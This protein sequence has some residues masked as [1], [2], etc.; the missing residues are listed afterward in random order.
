MKKYVSLLLAV[1]LML[2]VLVAIPAASASPDTTQ[3]EAPILLEQVASGKLPPLEER[4]PVKS[5]VMVE[6]DVVSLG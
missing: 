1:T 5:D 2:T 6:P 3:K 4:L